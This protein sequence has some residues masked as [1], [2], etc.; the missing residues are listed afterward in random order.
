[1]LTY[2]T[3]TN[4]NAN[5]MTTVDT[6]LHRI[7]RALTDECNDQD[8]MVDEFNYA[9]DGWNNYLEAHLYSSGDNIYTIDEVFI[10]ND[11][12]CSR[13]NLIDALTGTVFDLSDTAYDI[14]ER[15]KEREAYEH[16]P[17]AFYG[18]SRSD[19]V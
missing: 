13:N 6:I 11:N 9:Y 16:D 2:N 14:E 17:Y 5:N 19:F 18:V 12:E 1:M 3:T 15:L 10:H 8:R 7:G 4:P